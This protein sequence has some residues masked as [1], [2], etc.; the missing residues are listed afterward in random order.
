MWLA[1]FMLI[2]EARR[3]S[4]WFIYFYS[5]KKRSRDIEIQLILIFNKLMVYLFYFIWKKIKVQ[6][7]M[8]KLGVQ[9]TMDKLREKKKQKVLSLLITFILIFPVTSSIQPFFVKYPHRRKIANIDDKFR[10]N[11]IFII[12][13][14]IF[15]LNQ[16]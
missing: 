3:K 5:K 14:I 2:K 7:I 15:N 4:C 12:K 8:D 6:N 16:M 9:N 11:I 10:K 1:H 13:T